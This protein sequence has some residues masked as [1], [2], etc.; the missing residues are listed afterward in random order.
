MIIFQPLRNDLFSA[1]LF[2]H[3]FQQFME[4]ILAIVFNSLDRIQCSCVIE[5][6]L[7]KSGPNNWMSRW[8]DFRGCLGQSVQMLA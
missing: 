8:V 2:T 1:R 5:P 7:S 6:A 3:E 4:G